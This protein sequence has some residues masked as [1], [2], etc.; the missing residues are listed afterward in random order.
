MAI[1]AMFL[2]RRMARCPSLLVVTQPKSTRVDGADIV[3]VMKSC[4]G[5]V[6][7]LSGNGAD[8]A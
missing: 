2:C 7:D 5:L 4:T 6:L 1:L 3:M 8:I